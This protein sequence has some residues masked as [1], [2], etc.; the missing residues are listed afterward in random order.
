MVNKKIRI[1]LLLVLSLFEACLLARVWQFEG[2][3]QKPAVGFLIKNGSNFTVA[4]KEQ[5][6]DYQTRDYARLQDAL[7]FARRDLD[8]AEGI[9]PFG[10]YELEHVWKNNR[11]GNSVVLWKAFKQSNVNQISFQ[12]ENEAN[13]FLQAFQRGS[14]APSLFGHSI[15]LVPNGSSF[16]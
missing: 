5:N 3:A 9:N 1:R 6:R 13:F 4:W 14:Y 7:A 2:K 10:E 11:Y 8:L 16:N 15:L 12:D